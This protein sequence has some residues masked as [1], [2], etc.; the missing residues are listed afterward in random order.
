MSHKWLTRIAFVFL[1]LNSAIML[2]I[3]WNGP[4]VVCIACVWGMRVLGVLGIGLGAWGIFRSE[5]MPG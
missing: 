4:H 3:D 1:I 2:V 5:P